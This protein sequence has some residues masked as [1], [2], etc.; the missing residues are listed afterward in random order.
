MP[1]STSAQ[2]VV[3]ANDEVAEKSLLDQIADQVHAG[4]EPAP[5]LS[6]SLGV[7]YTQQPGRI[8]SDPFAL[9]GRR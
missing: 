6:L 5:N 8:D 7:G 2:A 4:P 1:K 3:V 9:G